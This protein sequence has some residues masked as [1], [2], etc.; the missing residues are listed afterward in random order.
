MYV[1]VHLCDVKSGPENLRRVLNAGPSDPDTAEPGSAATVVPVVVGG[2]NCPRTRGAGG[3]IGTPCGAE[4]G[5]AF[6]QRWVKK[7]VA[8][9]FWGLS[10]Y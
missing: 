9:S 1:Q 3:D 7:I 4:A 6:A 8:I 10:L 2:D 5:W